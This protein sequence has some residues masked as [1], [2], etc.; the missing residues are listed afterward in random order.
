MEFIIRTFWAFINPTVDF[1]EEGNTVISR[2]ILFGR[3]EQTANLYAKKTGLST[4]VGTKSKKA[5][6]RFKI[7]FWVILKYGTITNEW[8]G[9]LSQKE[10]DNF[11][12]SVAEDT[13]TNG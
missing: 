8:E 7:P 3:N 11:E 12:N 13:E 10:I 4:R 1:D 5:T 9:H 6:L 2:E